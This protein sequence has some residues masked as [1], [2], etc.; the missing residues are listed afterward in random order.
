[1]RAHLLAAAGMLLLVPLAN[2]CV[3]AGAATT[4]S[5]PAPSARAAV[6]GVAG[7][8][9]SGAGP[10]LP[11]ASAASLAAD[12][13]RDGYVCQKQVASIA[14]GTLRLYVDDDARHGGAEVAIAFYSGM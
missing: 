1:M 3:R 4:D 8:C 12:R 13:N 2:G 10:M 11:A 9:P 6:T 14:G 7:D 5:S